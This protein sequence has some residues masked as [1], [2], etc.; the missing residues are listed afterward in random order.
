MIYQK[1]NKDLARWVKYKKMPSGKT[2]ILDNKQRNPGV[3]FKGIK[4]I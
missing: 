2:I 3:P 4:K 1:F